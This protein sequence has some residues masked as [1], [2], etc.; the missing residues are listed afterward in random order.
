MFVHS[1]FFWKKEGATP[2]QVEQLAADCHSL[3]ARIP[4]VVRLWAGPP[5]M[6]PRA[7]VD[8][9]YAVGL[10][11]ILTDSAAH[12]VYQTHPLHLEFI[13]RNKAAWERVQIYDYHSEG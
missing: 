7:V 13:A 6:T 4:G 8:N 2:A 1:V 3:L 12:E 11:V 10:T 5:A 9:S